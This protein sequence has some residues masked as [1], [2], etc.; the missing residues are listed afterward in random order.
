MKRWTTAVVPDGPALE[1]ARQAHLP[2]ALAR[3]LV[4]RGIMTAADADR[5][6]NPRL[7]DLS[8]PFLLPGMEA[9]V[10]RI[11][12]A[13]RD[14]SPIV[15]YGDYDVDGVTSA[16]LMSLVLSGLGARVTPL[17]PSRM[18]EGYGLGVDAVE[19]CIK[20]VQPGLIVTTDCGSGSHEAVAIA[21]AAGVDIVVT[22]H[23]ELGDRGPAPCHA[24]VN[25]KLGSDVSA[26]P[27]AGVGVAFKVCHGLLK[28]GRER[29][30]KVASDL[31]LRPFLDLVALGTVSDVVP[32]RHENRALVRHGLVQLNRR[33]RVGLNAL[34]E[35][36][37]IK[38]EM[39]TY[40]L[41]FV[42][43]PR[44][45]AA[46]RLG[47][48]DAALELLLAGDRDQALALA[49]QL[50]ERNRERRRIESE[51]MEQ[52]LEQVGRVH[53]PA[54]HHGIVVGSPGWHIGVI[55]IVASRIVGR[56][57]CPAVV[58]GFDEAGVGRGSCRSIEGFD[59]L[60]G[61]KQC[62]GFLNRYGGHEMA[63]GLEVTQERFEG[64]QGAFRQCCEVA[65]KGRELTRTL[66][67][68]GWVTLAEALDAPF[69]DLVAR[70]GPFG[71]GNT[72][73]LWG[74]HRVEVIGRPKAVGES[75]L[76]FKVGK[77]NSSCEAIGF[78]M[79]DRLAAFPEGPLDVAAYLRTN[80]YLGRTSPQLVLQDF[81]P[82]ESVASPIPAG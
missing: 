39:G 21:S 14:D 52:V 33:D 35:V 17:L 55:G 13:I 57:G 81:R 15:V 23:H 44:M 42:L 34:A 18:E 56:F 69:M 78:N 11:W 72:E 73:P 61:L 24:L 30:F 26:R 71:E 59:L 22:D 49:T 80:T 76:K 64:F 25:P 70:L 47:N 50:E 67:L 53:D 20:A 51:I 6:L 65:L 75:H 45:N 79:A 41:G 2:P 28:R 58:I 31:D 82:S 74:F 5:F 40:H 77:G 12:K 10:E 63:A 68:E 60:A 9:A 4:A 16:A 43:G 46:G 1:L 37:G 29:R 38:G 48:A 19:R 7:S 32:M 62:D 8:D 27:L 36:A 3:A 54:R 66:A